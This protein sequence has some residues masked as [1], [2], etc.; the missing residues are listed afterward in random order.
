MLRKRAGKAAAFEDLSLSK[1]DV[2]NADATPVK[3]AIAFKDIAP[4]KY[5]GGWKV[6]VTV[7]D[8][9]IVV[10]HFKTQS[11]QDGKFDID[12]ELCMVLSKNAITMRTAFVTVEEVTFKKQLD[13]KERQKIRSKI[14]KYSM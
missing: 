13:I 12:W 7:S 9:K 8:S 4:F 14:F 10:S 6:S 5:G 2:P 1:K 11:S 3:G